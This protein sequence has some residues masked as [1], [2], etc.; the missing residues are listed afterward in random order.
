MRSYG[1]YCPMALACEIV[2]ERWTPLVLRELACGR[3]RFNEI[4]RGLPRMS[5]S[6]LTRR[7]RTLA[8]AGLVARR[9]AGAAGVEYVLTESG[10][11][12]A[13]VLEGLAVW[14]K[15]WLPA[16]LSRIAPDPDLIVW[17]M[18]R[19]VDL[20]RLPDERT[21]LRFEFSDQPRRKRY[22][23]IVGNKSGIELCIKDPGH[24]V[25]LFVATDSRTLTGVWY[26]DIPLR[27]VIADGRIRLHGPRRLRELFPSWLR[28]NE[29][30]AVPRKV[31]LSAQAPV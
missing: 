13:P 5:P 10:A 30:A 8:D 16:T 24:E 7:L 6:L 14:G 22:R 11:G 21:V 15:T 27:R 28:L 31:P 19:R 9:R 1:Q 18:H 2:G 12:L 23:W 29:L 20:G 4:Q 26:G 3:R 17:D 25:D